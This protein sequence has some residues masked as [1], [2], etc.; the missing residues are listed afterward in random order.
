MANDCV[1]VC[2]CVCAL[3]IVLVRA[4][5]CQVCMISTLIRLISKTF[6]NLTDPKLLNGIVCIC[7]F[8]PIYIFNNIV[9]C[10][11]LLLCLKWLLCC[12]QDIGKQMLFVFPLSIKR[13]FMSFICHWPARMRKDSWLSC[14]WWLA[15]LPHESIP[16]TL[17][18][19]HKLIF[20][21][22]GRSSTLEPQKTHGPNINCVHRRTNTHT[23]R[24]NTHHRYRQT[25]N[26]QT[27]VPSLFL[28]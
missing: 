7:I 23:I 15:A 11:C 9:K 21:V 19:R 5:E 14:Q 10:I 22:C 6:K 24:A 17:Q 25:N 12:V 26:M 18:S 16:E 2:V 28:F 1:C 3:L 27:V 20:T 4:D 13:M 8:S